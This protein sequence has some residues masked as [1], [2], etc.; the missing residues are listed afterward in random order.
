MWWC[1]IKWSLR[2]HALTPDPGQDSP[3]LALHIANVSLWRRFGRLAAEAAQAKVKTV[4]MDFMV[5]DTWF[6]KAGMRSL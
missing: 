4:M 2:T 5:V 1:S 6:E 3:D